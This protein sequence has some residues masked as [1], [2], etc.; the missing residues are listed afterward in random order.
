MTCIDKN[1]IR[2]LVAA[3]EQLRRQTDRL[4][5][6]VHERDA[7]LERVQELEAA[8]AL[9]SMQNRHWVRVTCDR[10]KAS[11]TLSTNLGQAAGVLELGMDAVVA[12]VHWKL[13]VATADGLGIPNAASHFTH[14]SCAACAA[15]LNTAFEGNK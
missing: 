10:C 11:I 9:T 6:V 2:E 3:H 5:L 4:N 12:V 14:D 7:L 15:L 1:D 8:L 13:S